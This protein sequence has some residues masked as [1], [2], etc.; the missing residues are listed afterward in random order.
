MTIGIILIV[1][2]ITGIVLVLYGSISTAPPIHGRVVDVITKKPMSNINIERILQIST[3][4]IGGRSDFRSNIYTATTDT[5]GKFNFPKKYISHPLLYAISDDRINI[6]LKTTANRLLIPST[7]PIN[8]K[9]Y[10]SIIGD[11]YSDKPVVDYFT[12]NIIEL[13]PVVEKIEDC[14]NNDICIKQN[15]FNLALKTKNVQLCLR[16][17][18]E[19]GWSNFDQSKCIEMFA[20][21]EKDQSICN[22]INKISDKERCKENSKGRD[23]KDYCNLQTWASSSIKMQCSQLSKN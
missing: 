17:G 12:E 6:N 3:S 23:I 18:L 10:P 22:L 9:Y 19:G 1:I 20:I 8:E 13:I 21:A 16:I 4:N 15:S 7:D 11:E 2:I 5:D 14:K